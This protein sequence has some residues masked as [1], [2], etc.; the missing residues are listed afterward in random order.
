[1]E[2][3]KTVRKGIE[4]AANFLHDQL[5]AWKIRKIGEK[6]TISTFEL[7][8]IKKGQVVT[9][10]EGL[11]PGQVLVVDEFFH[12][13]GMDYFSGFV[14][15][16]TEAVMLINNRFEQSYDEVSLRNLVV[17]I[18]VE[19]HTDTGKKEKNGDSKT[20]VDTHF[21]IKRLVHAFKG[22]FQTLDKYCMP[23]GND[24]VKPSFFIPAPFLESPAG[25]KQKADLYYQVV[26]VNK[27]NINRYKLKLESAGFEL[28]QYLKKLYAN[29]LVDKISFELDVLEKGKKKLEL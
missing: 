7:H 29:F 1:M 3:I 26:F 12:T 15:Q 8:G 23:M 14:I 4:V 24:M 11:T 16:E 19:I 27:Q 5:Q 17:F 20:K 6:T 9:G 22:K 18:D 2:R 25:E 10:L 28:N 13:T 21:T